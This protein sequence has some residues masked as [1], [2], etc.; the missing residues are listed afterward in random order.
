MEYKSSLITQ[1]KRTMVRIYM[2]DVHVKDTG[3]F[4]IQVDYFLWWLE[5]AEKTTILSKYWEN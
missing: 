4:L 1:T 5:M 2:D 3:L